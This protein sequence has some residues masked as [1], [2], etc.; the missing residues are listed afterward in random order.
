M[1]PLV[2]RSQ[3]GLIL[4][5]RPFEAHCICQS[6][7]QTAPDPFDTLAEAY[8]RLRFT[9]HDTNRHFVRTH[10]GPSSTLAKR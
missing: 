4:V 3:T 7:L 9:S 5:Y 8:I 2:L 1:A 10:L 6:Q